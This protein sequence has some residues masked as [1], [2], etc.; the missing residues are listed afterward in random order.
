MIYF[1]GQNL[2][3]TLNMRFKSMKFIINNKNIL[4]YKKLILR[5]LN[6]GCES[7]RVHYI[8]GQEF[9]KTRQYFYYIDHN[10][11]VLKKIYQNYLFYYYLYF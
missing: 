8:Q 7:N 9:N 3:Q 2:V 5:Q 6:T 4:I 10:G 11:M 1:F